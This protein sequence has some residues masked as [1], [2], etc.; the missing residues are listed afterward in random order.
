M[1]KRDARLF[2]AEEKQND[3]SW[4]IVELESH[5]ELRRK[6]ND[7]IQLCNSSTVTTSELRQQ[8]QTCTTS[9]GSRFSLHLARSLPRDNHLDRQ[10]IVWLLT[11][12]ND[13]ETIPVLQHLSHQRRLPRAIRLS[14][15][16]AL[17]GMGATQ[18]T[19]DKHRYA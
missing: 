15:A 18:E 14:A 3:H 9:F 12:L 19:T 5:R 16:L 4:N 13:K 10:S 7:L 2:Q 6:I 17:A 11:L 1:E 8:L